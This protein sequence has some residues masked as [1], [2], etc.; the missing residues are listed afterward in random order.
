MQ[1]AVSD[2]RMQAVEAIERVKKRESELALKQREKEGPRGSD[3]S[4]EEYDVQFDLVKILLEAT[5]K[6]GNSLSQRDV[7]DELLGMLIAGHETSARTLMW[8]MYALMNNPSVLAKVREEI[9]DTIGMD[10]KRP[11]LQELSNMDYLNMFIKE[12]LRMYP[13]GY[14]FSRVTAEDTSLG[15]WRVPK[16]TEV[17]ISPLLTHHSVVWDKPEVFDPERWAGDAVPAPAGTYFPFGLGKRQCIGMNFAY[18]EVRMI[19]VRMLQE[20]DWELVKPVLYFPAKGMLAADGD[21]LD[22]RISLRI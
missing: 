10:N 5:D 21:R 14:I 19:L 3:L 13:P 20:F 7:E 16:G 17:F 11:T 8:S 9:R 6:N 12:S 1:N 2:A 4:E 15:N 18:H 22:A